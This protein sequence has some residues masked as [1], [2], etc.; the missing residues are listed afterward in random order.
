MAFPVVIRV[1]HPAH[2]RDVEH[3]APHRSVLVPL[4]S[5]HTPTLKYTRADTKMPR[6]PPPN[7]GHKKDWQQVLSR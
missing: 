1:Q 7:G 6:A 5:V 4:P 2:L 3:V